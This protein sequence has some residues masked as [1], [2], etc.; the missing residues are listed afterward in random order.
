MS[1]ARKHL[2]L[3]ATLA[4]G[5]SMGA[6][7]TALAG[8]VSPTAGVHIDP[9]SP[10][11]KEY[12]LPLAT[13]RGA[14]ADTGSTGS[15]FG[16]GITKQKSSHP[17]VNRGGGGQKSD[18]GG[19]S[20]ATGSSPAATTPAKTSTSIAATGSQT[21][22]STSPA[23]TAISPATPPASPVTTTS[24]SRARMPTIHRRGHGHHH[25][26]VPNTVRRPVHHPGSTGAS[27]THARTTAA[28]ATTRILHPGDGS[29]WL[30]M[31]ITAL[32]VLTLG[33]GGAFLLVR[34]RQR[35]PGPNPS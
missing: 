5:V 19:S 2:L 26:R 31:L 8:G 32:A 16:R 28:P 24:T 7:A 13:A 6:P 18:G 10:V 35:T 3:L 20:A 22:T 27:L 17:S 33:S 23:I 12:A 30:W 21:T 4:I 1:I 9:S 11:A 15:L 34:M 14:P 25:R 29:G